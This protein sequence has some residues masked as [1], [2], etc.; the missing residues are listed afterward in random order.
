MTRYMNDKLPGGYK[1]RVSASQ[2]GN[3]PNRA[4]WIRRVFRQTTLDEFI[5]GNACGESLA[6]PTD[7]EICY[8]VHPRWLKEPKV[9]DLLDELLKDMDSYVNSKR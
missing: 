7:V 5:E 4:P 6:V 9:L 2:G 3:L 1:V 8:T